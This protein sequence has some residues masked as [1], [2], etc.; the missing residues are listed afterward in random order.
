[1][2]GLRAVMGSWKIMAMCDPRRLRMSSSGS[3]SRSRGPPFENRIWPVDRAAGGSRRMRARAVKD[4]PEPDSPTSPR[5][6]RGA[7]V[8]LRSRTAVSC[9]SDERGCPSSIV[10]NVMF[11]LRT[12]SSGGT[13]SWYQRELTR[14]RAPAPH[15]S[16]LAENQRQAVLAV[17]DH[18][19]FA[20]RTLGEIFRGLDSLPLQQ[21][22]T[23]SLRYYLLEVADALSFD[24]F[25]LGFLSF[26]LQLE[27]HGQGVLLGLL[28][29]LD[30]GLQS[31]RELYVAQ[32]NAFHQ[33]ST[34]PQDAGHLIVDLLGH[35]FSLTRVERVGSVGRRRFAD[36]GSQVGFDQH[37]FVAGADFLKYVRG[38]FRIKMVDQRSIEIHDQ[39]FAGGDAGGFLDLLGAD[40]QL[41]VGLEGTDDVHALGQDFS[42]DTAEEGEHA[43]VTGLDASD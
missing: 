43:D 25:A 29:G 22:W 40:G 13:G 21:L 31:Q 27:V 24:A 20:V 41:V 3:C 42:G 19:D 30:R 18:D 36:G 35:H 28:F 10:G 17:A 26:F 7:R 33:D 14:A 32:Q 5:T 1:M 15:C 37:R 23:D 12:S 6:S 2:T 39:A 34:G 4:F 9:R 38:F 16:S 11:R 8:K